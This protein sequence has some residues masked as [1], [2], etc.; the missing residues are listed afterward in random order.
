MELLFIDQIYR[1]PDSNSGQL[2]R[3]W[4]GSGG[5]FLFQP[6]TLTACILQPFDLQ[7]PTV[8]LWKD[9]YPLVTTYSAQVSGSN[10]DIN[11]VLPK[12][13]YLHM[14]DFVS[15]PIFFHLSALGKEVVTLD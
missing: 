3:L 15:G 4:Q 1:A 10:L 2:V 12:R 9:L 13:L 7:R 5:R 8:P 11:F 6:S 14:A